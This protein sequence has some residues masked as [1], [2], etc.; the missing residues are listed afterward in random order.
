MSSQSG[1][2]FWLSVILFGSFLGSLCGCSQSSFDATMSRS[3]D[4]MTPS[5]EMSKIIVSSPNVAD[6]MSPADVRLE[7]RNAKGKPIPHLKTN[8]QVSGSEN[9]IVPCSESD[10]NGNSSCKLYSTWAEEK[11]ISLSGM[12]EIKAQTM[13]HKVSPFK[14]SL[15]ITATGSQERL[16]TGHRIISSGGQ[17]ASPLAQKDSSGT[18]R[19]YSTVIGIAISN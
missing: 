8:I 3:A 11:S 7:L 6:G 13:F 1:A 18:V 15:A 19:M 2:K 9:V 16:T 4:E 17:V 10:D 14:S 5:A 12:S